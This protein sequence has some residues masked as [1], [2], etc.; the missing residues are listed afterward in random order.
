MLVLAN[1]LRTRADRFEATRDSR[2]VFTRAYAV[3]TVRLGRCLEDGR[4]DDPEWVTRLAEAF[5]KRYFAALDGKSN[6]TAWQAIFATLAQRKTSVVEDLIFPMAGHIARDL[7]YALGDVAF[8]EPSVHRIHD[9]QIVNE[10]MGEAV[11]EIQERMSERYAPSI[12]VL[13]RLSEG[14]DELL[15]NYGV[16]LS[17]GMAWYNAMRLADPA[18]K[19]DAAAA[20]ERSPREFMRRVM[21]PPFWSLR[22]GFWLLRRIVSNRRRWPAADAWTGGGEAR[23]E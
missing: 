21:N 2:C 15:T 1:E 13:D 7:P 23:T 22:I 3:M 18:S 9:F 20:I 12:G 11:D 16:R 6:S 4:I 19:S 17:R 5:A 14:Y 8:L 10:I